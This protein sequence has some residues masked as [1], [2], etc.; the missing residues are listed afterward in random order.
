MDNL[1]HLISAYFYELWNEHEYSSWQDAVD[2]FVR[3]S[4]ERAAIVPS[5][6]TN[7]LA[8]DR[9]DEDLAEQLARW[10]L[11]AQTPDGERAWLSGVRDR[12][13]SDLASEPA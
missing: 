11:D 6:I 8:G 5:E 4:P 7:F 10:G 12:I 2:D 13:T 1:K 9:S 3:R